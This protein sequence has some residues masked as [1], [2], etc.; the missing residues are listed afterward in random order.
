MRITR[1]IEKPLRLESNISNAFVNFAH[2]TVSLIAIVTDKI[3]AG[4]PLTGISFNSIGRYAQSGILKDRMIPRLL[5]EDP[6]N[7][8]LEDGTLSPEKV[9][10]VAL[11][12]EKPGGHGDRAHALAG[13][14]LAV[15]DLN[16]KLND[17]PAC[18]TIARHF[19]REAAVTEVDVYAAGGYYY[20]GEDL[21][22][23]KAELSRY[24]AQGF[25]RF[26]MK[27]G[28]ASLETDRQ[29][30]EAALQVAGGGSRLAV[31]A[32]GR[33]DLDTA[34]QYARA[35]EPYGLMWFEEAGDPLDYELNCAL[36]QAYN[37]PLA[38]GENLFSAMDVKNLILFGGM[39][40]G[41]DVF[42]MD[43]G[44]S[45]GVTEYA[46]MLKEMES[47]G[48][49]RK[50]A[51]PHGGQLLAL[52]VVAGLGLG[53][54]EVYPSIFQPLGGFG[55]DVK[56]VDG[57]V[58]VGDAPGFGLETKSALIREFAELVS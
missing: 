37:G 38:T 55:D 9:S 18:Q 19:G 49:S 47:R 32:N 10:L 30:I 51:Y 5:E 44:L 35:L 27:I 29:R 1:I 15:W 50:Q 39:R 3:V 4:K 31:D 11:R 21:T 28:G 24:A 26:K 53:G 13:L 12:N 7:L 41:H 8:L 48:F 56:V 42:Q 34:L 57:K 58:R 45:Y 16:A 23:L 33:F 20:P 25:T 46:R 6:E 52:H 36:A 14:E 40:P 22:A 17:E 43:S 2:H 54:C